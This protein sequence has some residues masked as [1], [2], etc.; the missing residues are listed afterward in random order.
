MI[1]RAWLALAAHLFCFAAL[2]VASSDDPTPVDPYWT[3]IHDEAVLA[4]LKLTASQ[5][6]AMRAALDPLDLQCFPLRNRSASE[7]NEGFAKAAAAARKE[8]AKILKPAQN[9]RLDQIV[10][11]SQGTDALLRDDL[12]AKIKLTDKQREGIRKLITETRA[13]KAKLQ[14]DLRANKLQAGEAQE[15]FNKLAAD[16]RDAINALLTNDQKTR[17]A[18]LIARDFDISKLGSTAFKTPELIGD[19]PAWLGSPPLTA[20]S[21]RGRVVVVHYFA[22]GCINCIHNYPTYREWQKELAGKNVQ[23][24]GIHTPETKAEHDV[25]KLQTKLKA[26]ELEFPVLVDN[27]KANW[28]AW[29]N[30]MWPS[31]YVLDKRGYMRAFWSGELKWQGATGDAQMRTMIDELLAEK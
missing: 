20:E 5:G 15:K 17:L 31:V 11:R 13:A 1:F 19:S 2:A 24:I 4:D 27:E 10:V 12:A 29:G 7:A 9:Q 8:L 16:D 21:L 30:N 14:S 6:E 18:P 28:N 22:F 23:L 26:E 25:A 3:L